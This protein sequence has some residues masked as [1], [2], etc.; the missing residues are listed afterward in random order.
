MGSSSLVSFFTAFG[1]DSFA[2]VTFLNNLVWSPQ[3]DSFFSF[4]ISFLTNI[5]QAS[6]QGDHRRGQGEESA[7]PAPGRREP[8]GPV[9]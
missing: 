9:N 8:Q 1:L 3:A 6:P 7:A 2:L 5:G 4:V